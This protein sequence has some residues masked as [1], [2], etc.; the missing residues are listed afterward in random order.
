MDTKKKP[1]EEKTTDVELIKKNLEKKDN[2]QKGRNIYERQWL[3]NIA[4]LFGKQYLLLK[5][6]T[7]TTNME[8]RIVWELESEERKNRVQKTANYI[9]PLYRSLLSRMLLMKSHTSVEPTT[10]S[11]RDKSAARVGSEALEDFWQNCNKNNNVLNQDLAGMPIILGK[12]FGYSLATGKAY[13]YPYFNS[14]TKSKYFIDSSVQEPGKIGEVECYL[15][16]QFDVFED[17]LKQYK[18]VQRVLPI[19]QIKA[20]YKIDVKA[21]AI[22]YSDIQQQLLNM[23]EG[24]TD[25]RAKATDS[26]RIFEYWEVPSEEFPQ[27]RFIVHTTDTELFNGVIP[28]EYKGKIPLFGINYLDLLFSQ[29]PQGMVE[30]LI[31][32]QEEYNFTLTKI[33]GYKKQMNGKL[34]VPNKAKL[35]SKYDE[36]VGQIIFYEQGQ[37]PHFEVPPSPPQFLYEE[38]ARIRRDMEDIS[39][40]HDSTK[41]QQK[42]I[43]SGKAIE[44]LDDLDNNAL[45]PILQSNE[46]TLSFFAETVLDIIEAKY[47]EARVLAITGDQEEADVKTFMGKDISGNRRVKVSIGTSMPINKTDRQM[48]IMNL[49]AQGYIDKAKALE[50]MEFGDLS[51]LYNSIDEQAQKMEN[52]EMLNGTPRE[53]NE[54][55]Y[56]SAHIKVIEQFMKG[57]RFGKLTSEI[58]QLFL[59][60]RSI[61]QKFL[62]AEMQAA[63]NMNPGQ[64]Q[65][66]QGGTNVQG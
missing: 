29:Y 15:L 21:E 9:L 7:I 27:G 8:E 28:P 58:Q 55:D 37:E 56:H 44:N 35:S 6:R 10:N 12:A 48:F 26:S 11:E 34:K 2:I 45:T 54:W 43:R 4:F 63:A 49:A 13:L 65:P 52:S 20:Q 3:V 18:I 17:P 38:L 40:V 46:Q 1:V 42:D 22:V 16:S 23:L 39:A 53:P 5:Q 61:H 41:F 19:K 62:R 25:D 60:H 51:G 33:H 64:P 14:E 24:K 30:Q 47:E 59:Q 50:L 66:I 32:L 31:S 57:D 36:E